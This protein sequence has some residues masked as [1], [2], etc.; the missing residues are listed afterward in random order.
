MTDEEYLGRRIA[1]LI[2]KGFSPRDAADLACLERFGGKWGAMRQGQKPA[3][4][5]ESNP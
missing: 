2:L 4:P 5:Y 1:K 3:N